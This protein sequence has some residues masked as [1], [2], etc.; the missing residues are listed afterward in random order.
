MGREARS[1]GVGNIG[2]LPLVPQHTPQEKGDVYTNDYKQ[3]GR[4]GGA[5]SHAEIE[6]RLLEHIV[7]ENGRT[8]ERTTRGHYGNQIEAAQ[9]ADDRHNDSNECRGP[10]LRQY[11]VPQQKK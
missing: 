1:I 5:V 7:G 8:A 2:R 9:C 11:H 6:D 4:D 3:N 10:Q